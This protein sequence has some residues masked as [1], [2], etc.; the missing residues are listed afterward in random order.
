MLTADPNQVL[1]G[2]PSGLSRVDSA[3]G[4][5]TPSGAGGGGASF[6]ALEREA[7]TSSPAKPFRR[8]ITKNRAYLEVGRSSVEG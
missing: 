6:A 7:S 2:G 4:P 3:S 5:G 8:L 1:A